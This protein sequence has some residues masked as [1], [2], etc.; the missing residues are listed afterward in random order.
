MKASCK[1]IM[2]L[3][4]TV[5]TVCGPIAHADDCSK[6]QRA[7][8][9]SCISYSLRSPFIDFNNKCGYHVVVK[10]D[11][12]HCTD[13]LFDV[14]PGTSQGDYGGCHVH[15]VRCCRV[16]TTGACGPAVPGR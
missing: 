11:K 6:G 12:D 3:T 8:M 13:A 14:G 1:F 7:E 16:M 5:V 9:P 2:A 10:V 4:I 15:A